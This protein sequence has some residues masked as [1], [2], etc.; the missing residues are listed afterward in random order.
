MLLILGSLYVVVSATEPF[1]TIPAGPHV[2]KT[3]DDAKA[4][5]RRKCVDHETIGQRMVRSQKRPHRV[6][7]ISEASSPQWYSY[8]CRRKNDVT[9]NKYINNNKSADKC[10]LCILLK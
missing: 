1:A 9:N 10:K 2:A 5:K 6:N 4:V 8:R 3:P 7:L